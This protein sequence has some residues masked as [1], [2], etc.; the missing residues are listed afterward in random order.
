M[1]SIIMLK[2]KDVA[3]ITLNRPKVF[4]SLDT[5][6]RKQLLVALEDCGIDP[7][8]RAVCI[9]GEGRAFCAGQDLTE[10]ADSA[11]PLSFQNVLTEQYN[12]IILKIRQLEKPVVAAVNGVA[13]GAGANI[14]LACDIVV[15]AESASFVQAF[16]KI[17]LIPDSGGTWVL[18]RLIGFGRAS[19]AMLLGEKIMAKEAAAMGMIYKCISDENFKNEVISLMESLAKMPTRGLA[20]TKKALNE[21]VFAD[22]EQQLAREADLQSQAGDTADYTEGVNAFIQKRTPDFKGL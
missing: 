13:A 2:E 4:N 8:V 21:S 3:Y 5:E 9:M 16:S 6:M 14:A 18:P 11:T 1:D 10:A 19:A 15:A 7:S 12:P 22:F 20:L 17:G